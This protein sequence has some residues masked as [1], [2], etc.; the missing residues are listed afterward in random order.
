MFTLPAFNQQDIVK[1]GL[2]LWLDANDKT[3]YPGTGTTWRDLS[4]T[5]S[6]GSLTNGPTFNSGSGGSIVFD[7]V[8]DYVEFG[9]ILDLGI[10]SM[11]VNQWL[12]FSNNNTV[13]ITLS[14]A[15]AGGQNF[16]FA[17]GLLDTGK[18]YAFIQGDGGA[19]IT[20]YGSTTI[21]PNTWVMATYVFNRTST[22]KM[23]YNSVEETLT[24][25]A[26]I[27]QWNGLDFQS[28][29]PFRLATY[30]TGNNTGTVALMNGRIASTQV[31]FR[32]LSSQEI[33]QNYNA[34]RNRFAL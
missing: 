9:D 22:I 29:N 10:N 5:A 13:Q 34:T 21:P 23:Y 32:A 11:T 18:L 20:P 8:D 6:T 27:S 30:T 17:T 28:P 1:D 14:K 19:D 24:G 4:R 7:G 12:Y 3:S 16:R 2:V 31:Y 25:T 15:L 33:L 26:T